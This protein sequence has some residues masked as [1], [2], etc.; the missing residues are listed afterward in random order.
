MGHNRPPE[1]TNTDIHLASQKEDFGTHS[2]TTQELLKLAGATD[3]DGDAL[4]VT[5]VKITG[6]GGA[7]VSVQ[8]NGQGEF[9]FTSKQ[10]QHGDLHF[11][12][13]VTD[14]MPHSQVRTVSATLP[15]TAVNDNPVASDFKLG[16][17]AESTT[18]TPKPTRVFTEQ[19]FLNHVKDPDIA[20]DHDVLHL[21]GTPTLVSGDQSKGRF[22]VSGNGYRFVPSNLISTGLCML[23]MK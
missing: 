9:I 10:D 6:A 15:V 23:P 2:V 12:F 13:E 7:P 20:T 8:D 1:V 4:H 19:E 18:S 11:T 3:P 14:G 22:E 5:H 16:S 21:T 17:V